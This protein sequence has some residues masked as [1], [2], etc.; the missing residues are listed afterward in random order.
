MT[1]RDQTPL[2]RRLYRIIFGTDTPAGKWFDILL[3]YAILASVSVVILDSMAGFHARHGDLLHQIEWGFTL[4]FTAEYLLRIWIAQN[5][6]AYVLSVYGVIDL[7]SILPTYLAL[8]IPETAP[9][10][11]IRLIRIL[12]DYTLHYC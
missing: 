12:P 4:L 2:Q 3:I 9:L 10:L 8:L 1:R 11:I 5:R 6:R 7:L